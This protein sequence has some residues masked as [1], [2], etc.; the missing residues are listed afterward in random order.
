ME[1]SLTA[2]N[3]RLR[4]KTQRQVSEAEECISELQE[5]MAKVLGK[6]PDPALPQPLRQSS[7]RIPLPASLPCETRPVSKA[8]G[9]V[10]K[11]CSGGVLIM[12]EFCF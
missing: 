1:R 12:P 9:I 3:A 6:Q 7:A 11:N 4:E 5:E 8:Q 2:E 10:I